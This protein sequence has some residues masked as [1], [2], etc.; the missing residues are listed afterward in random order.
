MQIERVE[1]QYLQPEQEQRLSQLLQICFEGYP[2]DRCFFRQ[3]PDFRLIAWEGKAMIGQTSIEFRDIGVADQRFRIF[4]L[5]DF[6]VLPQHRR[7]GVGLA[8]LEALLTEARECRIDFL[9][10]FVS[11]PSFYAHEAFVEVSHTCRWVSIVEDQT[12]GV[13]HK[14]LSGLMVRPVGDKSWPEDGVVDLMGHIF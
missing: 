2:G 9:L 6:C 4:G 12:L 14:P 5:A 10:S 1:E 8:L 13:F 3:R 11:D 7:K